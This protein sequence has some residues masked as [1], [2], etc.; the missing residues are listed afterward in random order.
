MALPLALGDELVPSSRLSTGPL[1][2]F[3][4]IRYAWL[5]LCTLSSDF[6]VIPIISIF[7]LERDPPFAD[8]VHTKYGRTEKSGTKT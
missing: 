4:L 1:T 6:A 7:P 8:A 2:P 5:L 3:S